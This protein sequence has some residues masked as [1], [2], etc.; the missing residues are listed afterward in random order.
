MRKERITKKEGGFNVSIQMHKC[1]FSSFLYCIWRRNICGG[2]SLF[3]SDQ[4]LSLSLQQQCYAISVCV[5]YR[6]MSISIGE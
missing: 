6:H 3:L 2:I 4:A 5:T 1:M